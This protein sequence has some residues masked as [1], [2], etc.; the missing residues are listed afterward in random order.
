MIIVP[1]RDSRELD[2]E[3]SKKYIE[4]FSKAEIA[5][6]LRLCEGTIG[7]RLHRLFRWGELYPRRFR[8]KTF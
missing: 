4:G 5:E 2:L 7:R 6:D 1:G 3:I 8:R